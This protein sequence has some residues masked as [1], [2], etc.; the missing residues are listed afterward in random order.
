MH[1]L[2]HAVARHDLKGMSS[3]DYFRHVLSFTDQHEWLKPKPFAVST[4]NATVAS[5]GRSWDT[6]HAHVQWPAWRISCRRS[7]T[8]GCLPK[9][10]SIRAARHWLIAITP[11]RHPTTLIIRAPMVTSAPMEPVKI[12]FTLDP[13]L[14]SWVTSPSER[15]WGG[16]HHGHYPQR[17]LL[18]HPN[19][20]CRT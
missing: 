17:Y 12:R 6:G 3:T 19:R 13:R 2:T 14:T 9:R 10:E 11:V 4:D 1:A 8:M 15:V 7:S 5:A 16:P 18:G 20:P